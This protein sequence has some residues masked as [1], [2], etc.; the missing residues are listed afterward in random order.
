MWP[1]M[2]TTVALALLIGGLVGCERVEEGVE[3]LQEGVG[4]LTEG[5]AGGGGEPPP[6]ERGETGRVEIRGPV[7]AQQGEPVTLTADVSSPRGVLELEWHLT[8][9]GS[10]MTRGRDPRSV[11]VIGSSPGVLTVTVRV[12][13]NGV[14]VASKNFELQITRR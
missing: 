8:G 4:G 2:F 9:S 14:E 12:K 13:E 6:V 1:W 10:L 7:T 3:A 5:I 11:S